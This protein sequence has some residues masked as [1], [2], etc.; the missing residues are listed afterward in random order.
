MKRCRWA[1]EEAGCEEKREPT[2]S[3]LATRQGKEWERHCDDNSLTSRGIPSS[4]VHDSCVPIPYFGARFKMKSVKRDLVTSIPWR[5]VAFLHRRSMTLASLYRTLGLLLKGKV[6]RETC[7][8]RFRD[9]T[10]FYFVVD[11]SQLI[12]YRS[13]LLRLYTVLYRSWGSR[14]IRLRNTVYSTSLLIT[15]TVTLNS[16]FMKY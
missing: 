4:S 7:W 12:S 2:S 10:W 9:V 1:G 13:R 3:Y 8:R 16:Y 5:H 15:Y 11:S 6:L 14:I